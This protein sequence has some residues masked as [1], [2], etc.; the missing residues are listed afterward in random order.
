MVIKVIFA[1]N[2]RTKPYLTKQI[3]LPAKM[4]GTSASETD[5]KPRGP[6]TGVVEK[7]PVYLNKE[8]DD[9]IA[10]HLPYAKRVGYFPA[11]IADFLLR[12]TLSK[13][14]IEVFDFGQVVKYLNW[15]KSDS[16]EWKFWPLRE[17][18]AAAKLK[19]NVYHGV[20]IEEDNWCDG[21]V[22]PAGMLETVDGILSEVPSAHFYVSN[23][24]ADSD[25]VDEF[26]MIMVGDGEPY[27]IMRWPDRD[28]EAQTQEN[29][30]SAPA[31]TTGEPPSD[32]D[33]PGN[34]PVHVIVT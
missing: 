22:P 11:P 17:V 30:T 7:H 5:H 23:F 3:I 28:Q 27:V 34:F 20:S 8:G 10:V 13:L 24:E 4:V 14:G 19:C 16:N 26:L 6:F 15:H 18:D 2:D 31:S 25:P 33:D 9:K 32:P 12:Q 21:W 29:S 1:K